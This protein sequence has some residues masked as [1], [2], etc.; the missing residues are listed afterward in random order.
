MWQKIKS[1]VNWVWGKITQ[2]LCWVGRKTGLI[3]EQLP[4]LVPVV[5]HND[6]ET[7]NEESSA[8]TAVLPSTSSLTALFAISG[9][10]SNNPGMLRSYK[11]EIGT[12]KISPA[13]WGKIGPDIVRL[14][15]SVKS[16]SPTDVSH[17]ARTCKSLFHPIKPTLAQRK[18]EKLAHYVVLEPNEDKVTVI[19]NTSPALINA[20][21]KQI[22][23]T[24]GRIHINKTIFQLAYG[25]G[26]DLMCLAIKSFFVKIY[27]SEEAGIQEMQRQIDQIAGESKE[28]SDRKEHESKTH[29]NLILQPVIAAINAEQFNLGRNARKK[30][31]LSPHTLLAL[32]TF[33]AE[34]TKSQLNQPK[35]NGMHFRYN[36]LLEMYEAYAAAERWWPFTYK[37]HQ[38]FQEGVLAFIL[39]YLPENDAQKFSQGLNCLETSPIARKMTIH[40]T[41]NNFY[42]SLRGP[43]KC[44]DFPFSAADCVLAA[45]GVAIAVGVGFAEVSKLMSYK[46]V[47][48]AKLMQPADPRPEPWCVIC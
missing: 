45:H 42:C 31:I 1:A 41:T 25:A 47:K 28:E 24:A 15:A 38:V 17:L 6:Y 30:W 44:L 11:K 26:D 12:A 10:S 36:T 18:L 34:F 19:L 35:I 23:D 7:D 32:E 2:G 48:L 5:I 9:K 22:I 43:S 27:G 21:I 16:I 13:N 14:I 37:K 33:R 20:V 3:E 8:Q 40:N 29:F 46:K 4:P 39:L